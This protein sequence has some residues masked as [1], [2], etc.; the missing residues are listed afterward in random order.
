MPT[1][2][3]SEEERQEARE[4]GERIKEECE[5]SKLSGECLLHH[6]M[7]Y[8]E[9]Q[10]ECPEYGPKFSKEDGKKFRKEKK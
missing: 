9:E 7:C 1:R 10:K 5:H 8:F 2:E 3:Y 6:A 4:A